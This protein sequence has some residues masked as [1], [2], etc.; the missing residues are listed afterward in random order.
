M[1]GDVRLY[2]MSIIGQKPLTLLARFGFYLTHPSTFMHQNGGH[3][4]N[5][6]HRNRHKRENFHV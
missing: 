3:G 5:R 6:Y 2:S 4:N 1:K